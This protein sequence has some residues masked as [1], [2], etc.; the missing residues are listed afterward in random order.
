MLVTHAALVLMTS[1][2]QRRFES[3][4]ADRDLIGQAKGVLM[5]KLAVDAVRAFDLIVKQSKNTNTTVRVVAQQ[6]I[7]AYATADGIGD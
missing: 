4:L 2:R 5:A 1:N 6:V 3:A 7:D